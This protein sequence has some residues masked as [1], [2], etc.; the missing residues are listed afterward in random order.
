MKTAYICWVVAILLVSSV[1][2]KDNKRTSAEKLIM[3]WVG[4]EIIFPP[5]PDCT[6]MGEDTPCTGLSNVPYKILV[7]TDS[8]GCTS[9]R[10][11]LTVWKAYMKE[12]DTFAPGK[13]DF[14]FY[15]QPKN[16]KELEYLLKRE[17]LEHT[18]FIDEKGEISR[19]ND[20]PK[21]MEYQSFLLVRENKVLSI[22]NPVLNPKMWE[23]Y[24]QVITSSNTP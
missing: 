5:R 14:L 23:I 21:G 1:A 13:V 4:K 12:V 15:F 8:V 16:R 6:Y 24:K 19:I 20:F 7:Y 10:L 9:C 18:V 3:E 17:G 2:C 11:N 22:G